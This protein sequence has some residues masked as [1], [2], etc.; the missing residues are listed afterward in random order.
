MAQLTLKEILNK[1][2]DYFKQQGITKPRLDAEVLLA[3]VLDMERVK[4]YVNFDRPLSESEVNNYRELVIERTKGTPVAYLVG[5]KE[6]MSLEFKVTPEVLIPRPETEH[7]VEK[8]LEEIEAFGSDKI[9]VVDIGTGSGA[10]LISLIQLADQQLKGI[11]VDISPEALQIAAENAKFHQVNQQIE[12][13]SGNLLEPIEKE[14]EL[15]VS[16]PPYVPSNQWEELPPEVK[17]QPKLALDG[18][19]AGLDFY[20]RLADEAKRKLAKSGIII[21]EVGIKQAGQV[22]ELLKEAGFT[23]V[24][25]KTDYNDIERVVVGRS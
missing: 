7:L 24:E 9:T 23:E 11:G 3:D 18:G 14:V 19:E 1:T 4:L 8:A 5:K 13:R 22:A 25:I 21:L 2:V 12:W 20:H 6:F 10:I 15:I 17:K 16:N